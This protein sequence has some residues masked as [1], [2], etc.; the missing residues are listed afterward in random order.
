MLADTIGSRC[1]VHFQR[2]LD[3]EPEVTDTGSEGFLEEF[4]LR[5]EH[6]G[7][8]FDNLMKIHHLANVHPELALFVQASP[9]FC[10]PSM[11]TEAMARDIERLTGV[12]VVSVT[13]DGTG[14]YQNGAIVPYIRFA[15]EKAAAAG[16]RPPVVPTSRPAAR[17]ARTR[18]AR[19]G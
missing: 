9:A 19:A 14:Q 16:I 1:R 13:Y 5:P 17:R 4:G 8:S 2:F 7:E 11:V 15:A 10:C 3:P 6:A 18:T 12:P